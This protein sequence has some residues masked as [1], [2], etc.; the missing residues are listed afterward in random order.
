[1]HA[2][3]AEQDGAAACLERQATY[4]AHKGSVKCLASAAGLLASGGADDLIHLYNVPVRAVRGCVPRPAPWPSLTVGPPHLT[5]CCRRRHIAPVSC[6]ILCTST[7]LYV[8]L[9][10]SDF[11]SSACHLSCA[12]A[13]RGTRGPQRRPYGCLVVASQRGRDMGFLMNPGDGAVSVLQFFT[14]A[15]ASAPTHLLNGR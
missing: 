8:K 11:L 4:P 7:A 2:L 3:G 10:H 13:R 5:R 1:M 6:R 15:A 9:W 12:A 14:P